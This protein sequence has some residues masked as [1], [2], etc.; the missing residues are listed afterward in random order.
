[1]STHA[2]NVSTFRHLAR[3]ASLCAALALL[4]TAAAHAADVANCTS[5]Q[6]TWRMGM[7]AQAPSCTF[8]WSAGTSAGAPIDLGTFPTSGVGALQVGGQ[9]TQTKLIPF[10]LSVSSCSTP[11]SQI[12][13]TFTGTVGSKNTWF[14]MGPASNNLA[15][16]MCKGTGLP[17]GSNIITNGQAMTLV[18]NT[19]PTVPANGKVADFFAAPF[20]PTAGAYADTGA[21][22]ATASLTVVTSYN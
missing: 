6:G 12:A 2:M 13:V 16:L 22:G 20:A 11:L 7:T 17:C 14:L 15:F 1:M 19:S 3:R 18:N 10:S 9:V 21:N 4:S 8:T 5:C